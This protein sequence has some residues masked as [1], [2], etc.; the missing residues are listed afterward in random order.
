MGGSLRL[1]V[2][3]EEDLRALAASLRDARVPVC[4]AAYLARAGEFVLFASRYRWET[5]LEEH[6][7][8]ERVACA[9]TF[10]GVRAV[11]HKGFRLSEQG[12][13]LSLV[14]VEAEPCAEGV[15]VTLICAEG[16]A[17]RVLLDRLDIVLADVDDPWRVQMTPCEPVA[18]IG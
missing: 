12:R 8:A 2:G 14:D 15:A 9:L 3:D 10:R 13:A 16:C 18:E 6:P 5:C 1:S 4:E 11:K 7:G 17:I